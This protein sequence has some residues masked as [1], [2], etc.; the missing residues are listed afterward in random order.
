M[1]LE[2]AALPLQTVTVVDTIAPVAKSQDMPY[3]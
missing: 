1:L 2:T 3:H